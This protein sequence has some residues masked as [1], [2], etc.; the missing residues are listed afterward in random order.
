MLRVSKLTDYATVLMAALADLPDQLASAS[1][2]AERAQ[3]E[4]PTVSKLLKELQH[5]GLLRSVRGARG[6]YQLVS[7]RAAASTA[8]IGWRARRA[9]FRCST[10]S[11]RS[12]ARSA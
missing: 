10:S 8:A 2:L 5:A 12:K 1:E 11:P 9:R 7:S 6:G 3:I 4:L